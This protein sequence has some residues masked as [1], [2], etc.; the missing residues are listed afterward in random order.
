[1]WLSIRADENPYS[2]DRE[3]LSDI[4]SCGSGMKED[5]AGVDSNLME[6]N[7]VCSISDTQMAVQVLSPAVCSFY[8]ILWLVVCL[9]GNKEPFADISLYW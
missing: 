5:S 6:Q 4:A 2:C 7:T 8:V 1:M 9:R 3:A